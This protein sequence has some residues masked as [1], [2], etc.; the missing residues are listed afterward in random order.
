M[1]NEYLGCSK[2]DKFVELFKIADY[3]DLWDRIDPEFLEQGKK[4]E[5]GEP[6]GST[7]F[8]EIQA[9][10]VTE[11]ADVLWDQLFGQPA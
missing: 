8:D 10:R 6:E 7:V 9:I 2:L 5:P 4:R 11:R 3:G 1:D